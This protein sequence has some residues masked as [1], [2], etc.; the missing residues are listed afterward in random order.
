MKL[1]KAEK[2]D[3]RFVYE[4]RNSPEVREV[5]ITTDNILYKEHKEYFNK[6]MSEFRII[7]DNIGYIK[8]E[9]NDFI[10][11]YIH[12][13][14]RGKGI[15]KEILKNLKGKSIVLMNNPASLHAFVKSGWKIRG[16]Y[17][18]K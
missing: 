16:F 4:I 8:Y 15:G 10:G 7:G 5:C 2:E 14:N 18:E 1:R 9:E 12:K 3:C 13:N 11:I 6:H 17:L